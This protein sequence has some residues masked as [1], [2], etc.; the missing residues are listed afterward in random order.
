MSKAQSRYL[1]GTQRF[2]QVHNR[3]LQ[4]LTG[5]SKLAHICVNG[6]TGTQRCKECMTDNLLHRAGRVSIWLAGG[7]SCHQMLCGFDIKIIIVIVIIVLIIIVTII[8]RMIR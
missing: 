7:S 6:C 3:D 2:T 5:S 8:I 4:V 1:K